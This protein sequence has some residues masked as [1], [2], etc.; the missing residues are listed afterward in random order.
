MDKAR[1]S[2]VRFSF[3]RI[4]IINPDFRLLKTLEELE[5]AQTLVAGQVRST[6]FVKAQFNWD[7][8]KLAQMYQQPGM[9]FWGG[10]SN[11]ALIVLICIQNHISSQF[12]IHLILTH[13]NFRRTGAA[14]LTLESFVRKQCRK[15]EVLW[16]EVHEENAA[17]IKFYEKLGFKIDGFRKDYYIDEG[18][19]INMSRQV[20]S[21]I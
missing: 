5:Q 18:R 19:A 6:Q 13:V 12:D 2:Q 4:M 14:S 15:A 21:L 1:A 20:D 9:I 16:L 3:E 8:Q 7:R 10:F 17:A 11:Q